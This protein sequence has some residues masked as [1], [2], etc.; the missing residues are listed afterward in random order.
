MN[1]GYLCVMMVA[2]SVGWIACSCSSMSSAR[3][4]VSD[5]ESL[6]MLC[7]SE[8]M[9]RVVETTGWCVPLMAFAKA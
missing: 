1:C 5:G 7:A 8:S 6:R 4:A 3:L 9:A 2:C